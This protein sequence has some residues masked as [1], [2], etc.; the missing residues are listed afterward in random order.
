[1]VRRRFWRLKAAWKD[2]VSQAV[3]IIRR[4]SFR[5]ILIF[6]LGQGPRMLEELSQRKRDEDVVAE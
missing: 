6:G 1:V 5:G 3:A 4:E 2:E